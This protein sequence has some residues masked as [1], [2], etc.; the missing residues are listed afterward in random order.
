M[1]DGSLIARMAHDVNNFTNTFTKDS[2]IDENKSMFD[3]LRQ[4]YCGKGN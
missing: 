1:L 3:E 2:L 4:L